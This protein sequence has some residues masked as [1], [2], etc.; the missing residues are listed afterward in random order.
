MKSRLAVLVVIFA[1]L[2]ATHRGTFSS[3]SGAERLS[4]IDGGPG[5]A[6]DRLARLFAPPEN[7]G[8]H[9]SGVPGS[10]VGLSLSKRLVDLMDGRIG[11]EA[12]PG[13]GTRCWIE[14]DACEPR[15][16]QSSAPT[17]AGVDGIGAV[18]VLYV[19]DNLANQ[20]VIASLLARMPG[21]MLV[22]ATSGR[23]GVNAA[24]ETLPHVILLDI[25]LPDMDGYAVLGELRADPLT[26]S[27]PVVA[28]TAAAMPHDVHRAESVGFARYL[29][30]PV[31]LETLVESLRTVL[32]AQ[33]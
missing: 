31:H 23:A 29:T 16:A 4:V 3:Q 27:I 1:I 18:T 7:G 30:K 17:P 22:T 14:F 21:V 33:R 12:E 2:F 26:R 13:R 28:L 11:A 15:A 8:P 32:A 10:A 19:E 5:L 6:A 20:R 25:Q 9:D 24:R